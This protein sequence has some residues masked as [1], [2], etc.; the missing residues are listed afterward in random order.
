MAGR[1]F[2]TLCILDLLAFSHAISCYQ[3]S[4]DG[5][6]ESKQKIEQKMRKIDDTEE[7]ANINPVVY[8]LLTKDQMPVMPVED[9]LKKN[10]TQCTIFG[11]VCVKW[12]LL[13]SGVTLNATWMCALSSEEDNCF[14][15]YLSSSVKK[16]VCFCDTDFCNRASEITISFIW[17]ALL[18]LITNFLL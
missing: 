16:E 4:W 13:S 15:Q 10:C 5:V 17:I 6:K 1:V 11:G 14:V 12:V 2:V 8:P 7:E 18:T 3:C 9:D